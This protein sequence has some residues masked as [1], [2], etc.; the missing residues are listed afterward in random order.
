MNMLRPDIHA[1]RRARLRARVGAPILL[2]G[3]GLRDRNL[4]GYGLPFR[5]DSTF[6]YFTGCAVPN[7][8][9]LLTGEGATLFLQPPAED[10]ALWHGHTETIAQSAAALGFSRVRPIDELED[11]CAPLTGSLRTLAG[12]DN[13]AN[14]RA[15]AITGRST[16]RFGR[17]NGHEDLAAAVVALRRTLDAD[18]IAAMKAAS[19][20]TGQAHRAAMAVTRIGGHEREV[21]A[22]FS[23]VLAAHGLSTAYDS[24]VT[25]RGEVLHNFHYVNRLE[26]GQLLLLDGG[27]EAP[28]GYAN[29]VTRTWPVSGHFSARQ[30]AAY[31]AVLA[32]QHAAIDMVRPGAR[33]RDIHMAAARVIAT[34]LRDEGLLTVDADTALESGAHALFFPHGTGHLIGL[35][36]HDL[37]AFGDA[38]LYGP[39]R[40]RS[41]QFGTAYLRIDLDLQPG[42]VVTIEPGFYVVPAIL[43]DEA[44]TSR[45]KGQLD[46]DRARE[47]IG[48]GGIRIEDDVATTATGHDVLTGHIPKAPGDVEAAVQ[49]DFRW[50]D[51]TPRG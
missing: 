35:D 23:G 12:P 26:D 40:S 4:P 50:E 3:C 34:F 17:D 45:F 28:S 46:L 42:M 30:R 13:N 27:G 18:E 39:G 43:G 6:L 7:A 37:E 5:Q 9:M 2:V 44:L 16:L 8:A 48:F 41:D 21:S 33:Y 24:I 32:A 11:A 38:A 14:R 25:V 51:F 22:V 19:A 29:D 36:V 47:W 20:A 15:A 10:D 31:D 49:R 1:Q